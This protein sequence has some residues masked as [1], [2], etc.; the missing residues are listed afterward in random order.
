MPKLGDTCK[1]RELGQSPSA[2]LMWSACNLC[3][4]ERWVG[5]NKATLRLKRLRCVKCR[6]IRDA[7]WFLNRGYIYLKL[8][9]GHPYFGMGRK[10]GY[11]L[12]HRLVM[13]EHLGRPL[14]VDEFVHHKNGNRGDNRIA[15]LQ[16]VVWGT[17]NSKVDRQAMAE[18][19]EQ[20]YGLVSMAWLVEA[21]RTNKVPW[22]EKDAI[23][24]TRK[25][26]GTI[27]PD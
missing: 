25:T 23:H 8:R 2:N 21:L 19:L 14:K 9:P 24:T 10:D 6:H 5:Y 22:E 27:P 26:P 13:A 11:V 16:L 15:N 3:G 4:R 18:W 12:Q 20:N 7:P 1:G 17:H